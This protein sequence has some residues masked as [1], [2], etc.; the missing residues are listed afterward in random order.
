[1]GGN[2]RP[3]TQVSILDQLRDLA[4][5][6]MRVLTVS[7]CCSVTKLC[8]T[9]C[10]TNISNTPGFPVL[11]Y[12]SKFAHTHVHEMPSNHLIL[13]RPLRLLPSV[14]PSI[15]VFCNLSLLHIRWPKDWSFSTSPS[16]EYSS[17]I[18]FRIDRFDLFAVQGTARVFSS[19]TDGKHQF[20]STQPSL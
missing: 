13:F 20:F 19:T 16:N 5:L 2:E 9:L 11:H 7:H 6:L 12:L 18:P 10:D 14:F 1:M 17:L 15:R 8:P 4:V 3:S